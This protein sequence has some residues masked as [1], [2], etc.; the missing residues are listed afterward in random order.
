LRSKR[1]VPTWWCAGLLTA[2]LAAACSDDDLGLTCGTG[3]QVQDTQCVA[4]PAETPTPTP[5]AGTLV[6]SSLATAGVDGKGDNCRWFPVRLVRAT[7]PPT[8]LNAYSA[9]KNY[10][11]GFG[12]RHAIRVDFGAYSHNDLDLAGATSDQDVSRLITV[13]DRDCST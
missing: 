8:L 13:T 12:S 10:D 2:L 7:T 5:G 4:L 6:V 1:S 11:I 9:E 3:T